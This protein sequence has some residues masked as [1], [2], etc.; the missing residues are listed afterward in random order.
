MCKA[1]FTLP[2]RLLDIA[3]TILLLPLLVLI[4][5][6]NRSAKKKHIVF[7]VGLEHVINKTADRGIGYANRGFKTIFFSHEW[8]GLRHDMALDTT[9]VKY[10]FSITKDTVNFCRNVLKYQPCYLE[11][12]FEGDAL[13]QLFSAILAKCNGMVIVSIERGVWHG[14]KEHRVSFWLAYTYIFI[15]RLSDKIFYREL[16][17]FEIY[18]RYHLPRSKFVFDHNRV[19]VYKDIQYEE[20]ASYKTVLY[21]NSFK[22][23]RRVDL[24]IKAIPLVKQQVPDVH[25]DIVG[26]TDQKEI[27]F[28]KKELD[29]LD[30]ADV[31]EVYLWTPKPRQFYDKASVF[32]LPAELVFCNFSL[33]EA[34]ER[35]IPPVVTGVEDADKIIE[36]NVSGL[37]CEL[38]EQSLADSIIQLLRNEELRMRIAKGARAKIISDFDSEFRLDPIVSIIQ[39]KIFN[40]N[41]A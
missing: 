28:V 5:L 18:D 40:N 22:T 10:S 4:L 17:L 26:A 23:F 3:L 11:V 25:F 16:G 33:I 15:F 29:T 1:G 6:L 41:A 39:A 14:F 27:D 38:N 7:F 21:L 9:I 34:M 2:F 12:Y 13:R 20:K 36:H 37:L 19:P 30:A 35:G 8:S 24:L 32:V 31:A